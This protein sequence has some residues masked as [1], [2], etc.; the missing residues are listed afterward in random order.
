MLFAYNLMEDKRHVPSTTLFLANV[1]YMFIIRNDL[2]PIPYTTRID[3]FILV[4][5][6]NN[7]NCFAWHAGARRAAY[8]GG[9]SLEKTIIKIDYVIVIL[10]AILFVVL[11]ST[12][13]MVDI[14]HDYPIGFYIGL[15]FA[16]LT[17]LVLMVAR[18]DNE[19]DEQESKKSASPVVGNK[20]LNPLVDSQADGSST[21]RTDPPLV[22]EDEVEGVAFINSRPVSR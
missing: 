2:P 15:L 9:K 14:S 10:Y 19:A 20:I 4:C 22:V 7:L 18:S 3:N 12:S 6:L 21:T 8:W 16:V 11:G 5:L 13:L 17:L 1:T